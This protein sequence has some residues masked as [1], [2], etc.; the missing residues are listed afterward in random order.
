MCKLEMIIESER[1]KRIELNEIFNVLVAGLERERE[2]NGG[3]NAEVESR[4][5]REEVDT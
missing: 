1:K 4:N 3:E 2:E 5:L